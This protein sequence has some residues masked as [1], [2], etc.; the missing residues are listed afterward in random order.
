MAEIY[1]T[2]QEMHAAS[3]MV[4]EMLHEVRVSGP[5]LGTLS[6]WG[7]PKK[8]PENGGSEEN[9]EPEDGGGVAK[10]GVSAVQSP[11]IYAEVEKNYGI[12]L[13]KILTKLKKSRDNSERLDKD[14]ERVKEQFQITQQ[15]AGVIEL[16][17]YLETIC[18]MCSGISKQFHNQQTEVF[19][20]D[21]LAHITERSKAASEEAEKA[22][23]IIGRIVNSY[24]D[25]LKIPR[26]EHENEVKVLEGIE[27]VISQKLVQLEEAAG[28]DATHEQKMEIG[29]VNTARTHVRKLLEYV[30]LPEAHSGE[31]V[32][33]NN[34]LFRADDHA[35]QK[36]HQ[37]NR[38]VLPAAPEN[39]VGVDEI[40][41]DESQKEL[42]Q[43]QGDDIDRTLEGVEK[44]ESFAGSRRPSSNHSK[45]PSRANTANTQV[46]E[47]GP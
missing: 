28:N 46:F 37:K 32:S 36:H 14:I 18:K 42:D 40:A 13:A 4:N 34:R 30:N 38:V 44:A 21:I 8:K 1:A 39:E 15:I 2:E 9:K 27:H 10:Q 33:G 22:G 23:V 12:S 7:T 35:S 17:D 6:F 20:N 25:D 43:E 45:K 41:I 19:S 24:L 31:H 16:K 29:K 11:D 5:E 3:H 26:P 47:S